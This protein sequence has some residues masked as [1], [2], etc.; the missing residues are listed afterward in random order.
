MTMIGTAKSVVMAR[1]V[2][3]DCSCPAVVRASWGNRV[4][5]WAEGVL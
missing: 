2:E 3:A 1:L 4:G 5:T